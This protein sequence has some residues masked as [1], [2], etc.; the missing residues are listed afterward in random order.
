[1]RVGTEW[2][3]EHRYVMEQM[4]GRPLTRDEKV[5][6]KNGVKTDNRPENLELWTVPHRNHPNGQRPSDL[7]AVFVNS[8]SVSHVPVQYH[9][10]ITKLAQSVFAPMTSAAQTDKERNP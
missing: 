2:V 6:H 9:D 8:L 5:H 4:I 1:M 3:R 7:L 10:A